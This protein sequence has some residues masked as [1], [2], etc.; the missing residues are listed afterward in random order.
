MYFDE[1]ITGTIGIN[2]AVTLVSDSATDERTLSLGQN[3]A[4]FSVVAGGSLTL[5]NNVTLQGKSGNTASVVNV[6]GG[7]LVM[8]SGSKITGNTASKGG[9]V[10]MQGGT[11]TMN[12]GI[13]SGNTSSGTAGAGVTWT[14]AKPAPPAAGNDACR[15]AAPDGLEFCALASVPSA[16]R[17][18]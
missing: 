4:M 5:D 1:A 12:G 2:K 9:G 17:T 16:P 15:Q 8:E 13:I 14:A 10:A 3:G 6:Y 11:F 18:A 7:S